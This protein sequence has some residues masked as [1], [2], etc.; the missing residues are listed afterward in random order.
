MKTGFLKTYLCTLAIS[1]G[2]SAFPWLMYAFDVITMLDVI[3]SYAIP[4][5]LVGVTA[6]L[7]YGFGRISGVRGKIFLVL[8]N[9]AV[10]YLIFMLIVV[11][12]FISE[13]LQNG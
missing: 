10:Y 9:P 5:S 1:C 12:A 7:A 6:A 11:G 3:G 4:F 2:I 13:A 8:A